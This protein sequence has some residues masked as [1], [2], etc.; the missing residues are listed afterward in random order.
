MEE[1]EQSIRSLAEKMGLSAGKVIHPLRL[2]LT[3]RTTS[4]GIFELIYVLGKKKVLNRLKNA[5]NYTKKLNN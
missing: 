4:P 1:I 2:A 5:I 3:G